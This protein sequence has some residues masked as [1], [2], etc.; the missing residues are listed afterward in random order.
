MLF[1][2]ACMEQVDRD[3]RYN[4]PI[5]ERMIDAAMNGTT[6][7]VGKMLSRSLCCCHTFKKNL[8]TFIRKKKIVEVYDDGKCPS[9]SQ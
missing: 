2:M 5:N 3:H 7:M 8:V 4:K 6:A 9:G 1:S